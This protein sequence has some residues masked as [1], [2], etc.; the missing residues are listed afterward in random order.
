[1][2][3][4]K[5]GVNL[6]IQAL[7]VI[8]SPTSSNPERAS[9]QAHLDQLNA[10]RNASCF[11]GFELAKQHQDIVRH[12]GLNLL[13]RC[14]SKDWSSFNPAEKTQIKD[15]VLTLCFEGLRDVGETNFILEKLAVLVVDIAKREW[16]QTW[17][18]FDDVLQIMWTKTQSTRSICL[19]VLTD[20][21]EDVFLNDDPVAG[22]R[23]PLLSAGLITIMTSTAVVNAFYAS[24]P[25]SLVHGVQLK[26]DSQ[27]WLRRLSEELERG[28][29]DQALPILQVLRVTLSWVITKA[30]IDAQI[31]QRVCVA[32]TNHN[33]RIRIC[34]VDCLYIMLTR[35]LHPQDEFLPEIYTLYQPESIKALSD[36]W[37]NTSE[38]LQ[39]RNGT[40]NDDD[41]YT[42]LKKFSETIMALACFKLGATQGVKLEE[43][44]LANV[45][46]LVLMTWQ[47]NSL[48]ISGMS[49]NFWCSVLR[50]ERLNSHPHVT[51]RLLQ[52]LQL[53]S[54]RL[55]HFEDARIQMLKG[56]E[57][58]MYLDLDLEN[59]PDLHAFCTNYRR[60]AFDIVR[61]VVFKRPKDATLWIREQVR[62]FF[63]KEYV[64]AA[65]MAFAGKTSPMY[66]SAETKFALIEACLRG[67]LR[68][69][70]H[71]HLLESTNG[72]V[73]DVQSLNGI[74]AVSAPS[75]KEK[76]VE[77]ANELQNAQEHIIAWCEEIIS[78][79]IRDPL[80]LG[81]QISV[82]VAFSSFLRT[83]SDLLFK[84]LEKVIET[85][86]YYYPEDVIESTMNTIR[87]LR[88]R[89]GVELLRLGSTLP[90]QLWEIYPQLETT[91]N[92]ILAK[93]NATE[94]EH[95]I[96]NALLLAI[97]QRTRS[98]DGE[99][100]S[101]E[102]SKVL[103]KIVRVWDT[104]EVSNAFGS[105]QSFAS[106]LMIEHIGDYLSKRQVISGPQLDN[107]QLDAAG[108]ELLKAVKK[109][110]NWAWPIRAS[111]KFV[112]AT[113][114]TPTALRDFE[115]Q[116][117][118]EPIARIIP[119]LLRLLERISGYYN[120][121]NW[122]NLDPI[123]RL[124]AK[125]S[126][127]ERFW[128]HGV[129]QVT[130][131]EFLEASTKSSDRCRE[132][133]HAV[134]HF[135]RR[136]REYCLSSLGT[137]SL[138]G[139]SFYTLPNIGN[140][141]M[142]A[143]FGDT[144]GT[145][146]HVWSTTIIS[147]LRHVILNCPQGHYSTVLSII[148]TTFPHIVLEK[149]RREWTGLMDRGALQ[150]KEEEMED[151]E[152]KEDLSDEM[153]EES[154]LRHLSYTTVKLF[155]DILTPPLTTMRIDRSVPGSIGTGKSVMSDWLLQQADIVPG[156]MMLLSFCLTI[157]DTRSSIHAAKILRAIVPTLME[158]DDLQR[159]VCHEV[160]S[161]TIR[162]IH[163]S[164]FVSIQTDLVNLL[165]H[166]YYL[167]LGKSTLPREILLSI[168]QLSGD[169]GMIKQFEDKLGA[170]KSDRARR[171]LMH[172]LL[173][174]HEIVGREA[175]GRGASL[176]VKLGADVTTKE[177]I[178]RFQE[179]VSLRQE[180]EQQ[181][182]IL[183]K[184]EES[185]IAKL[186][187]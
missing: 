22:L 119:N 173:V 86:T 58:Q 183:V 88:G 93:E 122:Q 180:Q 91:V 147:S 164:Y 77:M 81:R 20:L 39:F 27:G 25:L 29:D 28:T 100:K 80:V 114:D 171:S 76:K 106:T 129:S 154:L 87:D 167:S 169:V 34:A 161:A 7:E 2:S 135:L 115:R 138:L 127:L 107:M 95:T 156:V 153:M 31:M 44:D 15:W 157:N 112:E 155:S 103:V 8:H 163:D 4:D 17:T 71:L 78:L 116:L 136:T 9:A 141:I 61:M 133:V 121:H 101:E 21:I 6:V 85:A 162:C 55:L 181:Q 149:L 178:R 159:Y 1:M 140:S 117:W 3:D 134:G 144:Q 45:L 11:F 174:D 158:S 54:Q 24:H 105:F 182:N 110:R 168:P 96:F 42:M 12:F 53:G 83:R 99:Q 89:C 186:F 38:M 128:L 73:L 132:L 18:D 145:S 108:Y 94:D 165:A 5:Q 187:E 37:R 111:R 118:R 16:L 123:L 131:D 124:I 33:V 177:V 82:L 19:K 14:I 49:N 97:S 70:E 170:A 179:S 120:E 139:E 184:D 48:I 72:S 69:R 41:A 130:R 36:V 10:D 151:Q 23:S 50:D 75:S 137:F 46:D 13:G 125:E 148:M 67:V 62:N 90:D 98:I 92:N 63:S 66:I 52:I 160:F 185:G 40:L 43:I 166:I 152:G 79:T 57:V 74:V 150:T 104:A 65:D 142:H 26:P 30:I 64:D 59:T 60:F 143:L 84:I 32:L 146:L 176:K 56:S 102:F 172:E 47:H 68:Y 35:P 175:Y 126:I 51:E 109:A 113:L